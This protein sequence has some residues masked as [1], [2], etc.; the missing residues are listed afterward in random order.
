M[1]HRSL[2]PL[3]FALLLASCTGGG[4]YLP[5]AAGGQ[6]EILVVMSKG[7]WEGEPGATVRSILEQPMDGLPQRE[8]RF[9]L[10]QT[11]PENFGTLLAVHHSVLLAVMDPTADSLG[12]HRLR[13]RH[14]RGQL[15]VRLA[16]KDPVGWIS[17]M[18]QEGYNAAD[19]LEDHQRQR[20]A[21]RLVRERDATLVSEVQGHHGLL[22]DIPGGYRVMDQND[23]ASWLQR[24]RM[25]TAGGLQHNVIEGVL[26]HT[27]PYTSDSTFAVPFLVDQRDSVTKALVDGPNEGSYMKVQRGFE[28]M[29][30]MPS[31]RAVSLNGR[32]AYLMRGLYGMHGA[33]MG[34]PFISLTTV[35]EANGRLV[36]VEGFVYAPHFDKREYVRELE[37]LLFSLR[38]QPN[39]SP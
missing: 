30:L 19:A 8:P 1:I 18:Q 15:I 29:D 26:I 3:S 9:K 39:A 10:A 36:T 11:T 14:A 4:A 24:D 25:V 20:V 16:A 13:D 38:L 34:G 23:S 5:D 2:V 21:M 17:L 7:H 22:L 31:S 37:A 27:H 33:K 6:G 12:A 32:Y 28:D 35:D